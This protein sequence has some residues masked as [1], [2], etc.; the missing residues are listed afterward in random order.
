MTKVDLHIP[1]YQ[2]LTRLSAKSA[3]SV[4]QAHAE[5]DEVLLAI[6]L[7]A[8][9]EASALLRLELELMQRLSSVVGCMPVITSGQHDGLAFIVMP[10]SGQTLGE[11]ISLKTQPLNM[12]GCIKVMQQVLQTLDGI[13]QCGYVHGDVH[14]D[15]LIIDTRGSILLSDFAHAASIDEN[16]QV[17]LNETRQSLPRGASSFASP[18]H[19]SGKLGLSVSDDLYSATMTFCA[20]LS[21]LTKAD[22][23][24]N[25]FANEL[26]CYPSELRAIINRGMHV[27]PA[28]RYQ[29]AQAFQQALEA[30]DIEKINK[31]A[32]IALREGGK[33][34][35]ENEPYQQLT[36]EVFSPKLK[37]NAQTQVLQQDISQ[38]LKLKGFI[39]DK[40]KYEWQ[41][42]LIGHGDIEAPL[43]LLE[44]LI[45]DTKHNLEKQGYGPWL[46]PKNQVKAN[47]PITSLVV[48]LM[49]V[50][51]SI[52]FAFTWFVMKEPTSKVNQSSVEVDS[53][54]F[55]L[56]SATSVSSSPVKPVLA[57]PSMQQSKA[58]NIVVS[59]SNTQVVSVVDAKTQQV[60]KIELK[61]IVGHSEVMFVMTQE[62]THELWR[63]CVNA[64]RCRSAGVLSTDPQRKRLNLPKHP[65][66]NVSW[67][68]IT[69]DFIPFINDITKQNFALPTMAQW[70]SI[71][72]SNEGEA[73]IP[74]QVHCLDCNHSLKEEFYRVTV[75]SNSLGTGAHELH[76]IYGNVQE[77]LQDCWQD[78]KLQIQ[79]CDQAPAVGGSYLDSRSLIQTRPLNSLLKTARSTTTG[80]RLVTRETAN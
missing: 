74:R 25:W 2:L 67:Y 24:H 11:M 48:I 30:L 40:Q 79:R 12:E 5:G 55:P 57:K 69:E 72:F 73:L 47:S 66:I 29:S 18:E 60:Y 42:T 34:S 75:P 13:H 9:E 23:I 71:A 26:P 10:Y 52:T 32:G 65:V 4:Y 76:H 41:Q 58:P 62:L 63:V 31:H 46:D 19:Q 78:V 50:S 68:D 61:R 43:A 39:S 33:H 80:F 1:G 15:N 21:S 37:L 49:L 64:G 20:M 7:A 77:W 51:I 36:T 44:S 59:D 16:D 17:G 45:A 54:A 38:T 35:S 56:P 3:C 22:E 53:T 28:E 27:Q 14:L 6:K 70:M 8:T